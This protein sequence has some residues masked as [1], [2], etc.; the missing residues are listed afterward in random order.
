MRS[1]VIFAFACIPVSGAEPPAPL[2]LDRLSWYTPDREFQP[3]EP[4]PW[5]Y[6]GV[7][8]VFLG[9]WTNP[10]TFEYLEEL[11]AMGVTVI[12]TGGPAPCFPLKK[13]GGADADPKESAV[14]KSAFERLRSRGMRIIIGVSPYAPAEVVR[15]HPEW[16]LKP[17]PSEKPLDSGASS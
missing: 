10:R 14:L 13:H 6:E 17:S 3:I 7:Q 2:T 4:A 15:A 16:R 8:K 9:D 11:A 5:V 1:A 12:H